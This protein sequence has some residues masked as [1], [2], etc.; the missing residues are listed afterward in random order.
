MNQS[1]STAAQ[2]VAM[3]ASAFQHECT[4][5]RPKSVTVIL[6]ENMAVVTLHGV[7]SPAEEALAKSPAGAAQVQ[8]FHRKLFA[9]SCDGLR[10]KIEGITGVEVCQATAEVEATT[11]TVAQVFTTGIMVQVFLLAHTVPSDTWSG[12]GPGLTGG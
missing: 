2:Q 11:G 6:G 12:S 10:Q 8:E 5:H 7:L 3:A 1:D 4:G 9:G